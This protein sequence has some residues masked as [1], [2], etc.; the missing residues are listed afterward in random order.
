LQR[1]INFLRRKIVQ[2][3]IR[4]INNYR[5]VHYF[6]SLSNVRQPVSQSALSITLTLLILFVL[7]LPLAALAAGIWSNITPNDSPN[8]LW[9]QASMLGSANSKGYFAMRYSDGGNRYRL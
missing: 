1:F 5:V 6:K 8:G 2:K 9:G 3:T 7:A 4:V